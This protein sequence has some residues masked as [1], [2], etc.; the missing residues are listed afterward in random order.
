MIPNII[1]VLV[2]FV[3][4]FLFY[5]KVR[6]ISQEIKLGKPLEIK[7]HK[8]KRW[9][10]VAK[11]AIGQSKMVSRPV[12]AIMHLF[13]YVGFII[14]NIEMLEILIDGVFGTH[15]VFS[16]AGGIYPVLI[17]S[18]EVFGLLVMFGCLIFLIRRNVIRVNRFWSKE[19][20]LWPRSDANII[21]ITELF[22][23]SAILIMN[24]T[25]GILQ[26]RNDPHYLDVG[27]F[28]FS[29]LIQPL[30]AGMSDS[31]LIFIERFCWWFHIVGVLAFLNYI[32]YSKH[33]HV[34][35]A[36]PNVYYSKLGPQSKIANMPSITSE[37]KMMLSGNMDMPAEGQ[38]EEIGKFGSNDVRDF[39]WKH[40][41]DAYTCS[42]C[43]RCTSRC[44]A[45]ITGKKLSP[46]KVVMDVRDRLEVLGKNIRKSGTEFS[47]DKSLFD[48]ITSEELWACTTCNACA[49]ECPVNIDPVAIIMEMRRYLV[50]EKAAAPAELNAIFSNIE[51]NGAPWQYSAEDRLLWA[52]D[53]EINVS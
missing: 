1:F 19:M 8:A 5:R 21:L 20:R 28:L 17:S 51:N 15:R 6:S 29:G 4:V 46:R 40:L 50:M 39:T 35:L 10:L 32:P 27:S 34:F 30:F 43:G 48:K 52:K 31:S 25:D 47:D 2:L 23:M 42:E 24:A 22:L 11:V 18:F 26:M 14:V 3:A 33:F 16:F 44:P 9:K 38:T 45:N 49:L 7:D 12:A 36:F 53:L 41:M 37:I 13:V